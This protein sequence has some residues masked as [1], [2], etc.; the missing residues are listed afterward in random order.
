MGGG[1]SSEPTFFTSQT[2]LVPRPDALYLG[3]APVRTLGSA[4]A[5]ITAA[6]FS[7]NFPGSMGSIL[8]RVIW[9]VTTHLRAAE[10]HSLLGV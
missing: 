5:I 6:S 3:G 7:G 2:L 8:P 4:L 9:E 1:C 10:I